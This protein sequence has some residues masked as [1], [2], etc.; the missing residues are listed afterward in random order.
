MVYTSSSASI[1]HLKAATPIRLIDGSVVSPKNQ[2][3]GHQGRVMNHHQ[4]WRCPGCHEGLDG[5]W[6]LGTS[7]SR[8]I[9]E[10]RVINMLISGV[11]N[12]LG[13]RRQHREVLIIDFLNEGR[14]R[15]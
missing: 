4:S 11:A 9:E 7:W 10:V 2:V 8:A 6:D 14:A 12:W 3:Q 1:S 5:W 13:T 15:V